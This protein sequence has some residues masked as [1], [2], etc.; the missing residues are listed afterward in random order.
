[1]DTKDAPLSNASI[2]D[3]LEA[4][5]RGAW[6]EARAAFERVPRTDDSPEGLVGLG[7][8]LW[9]LGDIRSAVRC[10]EQAYVAYRRLSDPVQAVYAALQLALIYQANLGNHAAAA[11]WVARAARLVDEFDIVPFRGW[12]VLLKASSCTEPRQS[13]TWA[14]LAR[15]AAVE[16][17]DRDLELCALSQIGRALIDQGRISDGFSAID[18]AMA[19]AL[20]G[21]G[22]LDTVVYTSCQMMNSCSRCADFQRVVQWIRATDRFIASYGC[23]YLNATCRAHYGAVLFAT[24]DWHTADKELQAALA[25]SGDAHPMVRGEALAKLAELRLAQGRTNDAER[26]LAGFEDHEAGVPVRARIHLLHGKLALAAATVQRR[27]DVVGETQ[28]ESA[29]LVELLGEAEIGQGHIETA[30]ERGRS[31]DQLGSTVACRVMRAHGKR[32]R[33]QALAATTDATASKHLDAA[34]REF[35]HLE[36]PYEAARTRLLIAEILR[37]RDPEVAEAE[38]RSALAVFEELGAVENAKSA[39]ELLREL[40]NRTG[41]T[42]NVAGLSNREVEVL[43]LVALGLSDKEIAARLVLSRH[44]VHRHVSNILM[45]LNLPSRAAAA[46]YAAQHHLV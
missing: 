36:M 15:K 41:A 32:L 5:S 29:Q 23:P 43:R 42:F 33:G 37:E 1:M 10:W 2:Q 45:K 22:R 35:I 28:L 16:S 6:E 3:G 38:A 31:L 4:L 17:A 14:R 30:A 19:G 18:E 13:E 20:A 11:G 39:A 21:E 34:L 25:L 7:E 8:A 24:G 46:A 27:L 44:T 12:V 9:W 40:R 26:L